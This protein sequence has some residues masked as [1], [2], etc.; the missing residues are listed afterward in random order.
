[1]SLL[2]SCSDTKFGNLE[3][4]LQKFCKF[5]I[6]LQEK[7]IKSHITLC[8]GVSSNTWP[9]WIAIL[10]FITKFATEKLMNR[11]IWTKHEL[12]T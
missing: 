10:A 3:M 8:K 12:G 5:D 6:F 2:S 11:S 4:F 1:M 7:H 9:L